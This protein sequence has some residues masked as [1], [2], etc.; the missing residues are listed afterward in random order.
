MTCL[1]GSNSKAIRRSQILVLRSLLNILGK[2]FPK[3]RMNFMICIIFSAK[4]M[5]RFWFWKKHRTC[6][7]IFRNTYLRTLDKKLSAL[8]KLQHTSL[9]CTLTH[10]NGNFIVNHSSYTSYQNCV[11]EFGFNSTINNS[12]NNMSLDG[13][14]YF[15]KSGLLIAVKWRCLPTSMIDSIKNS[16]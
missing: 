10:I 9:N 4:T 8:S 3:L 1:V 2:N 15:F 13:K 11:L 14:R 12:N 5:L 16:L 7:F 6:V